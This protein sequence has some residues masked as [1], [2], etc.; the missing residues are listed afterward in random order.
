MTLIRLANN[1]YINLDFLI[2][3]TPTFSPAA[4]PGLLLKFAAPDKEAGHG[5][6][7]TIKPYE[8]RLEGTDAARVKGLLAGLVE[9]S[10]PW[11]GFEPPYDHEEEG[12]P[13]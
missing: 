13:R 5:H 1:S 8:V 10:Q 2:E 7:S 9:G 12:G 6:H 4:R 11:D 3:A